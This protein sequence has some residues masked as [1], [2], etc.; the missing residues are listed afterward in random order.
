MSIFDAAYDEMSW[1][2]VC[3]RLPSELAVRAL[4]RRISDLDSMVEF[5]ENVGS[6]PAHII[7]VKKA[8][9]E[10]ITN[11]SVDDIFNKFEASKHPL[12]FNWL[13][14]GNAKRMKE[15][16]SKHLTIE[17]LFNLTDADDLEGMQEVLTR[18]LQENDVSIS[19]LVAVLSKVEVEHFQTLLDDV[20][21]DSR[22]E[23]RVSILGMHNRANWGE[24]SDLQK[25]IAIK[26]LA[27]CA[28]LTSD[29]N[30][31][32]HEN[33]GPN[34][35]QRLDFNLFTQLKPLERL[36][37]LKKYFSYFP[38]FHKIKVFDPPP[39]KEEWDFTLFAGCIEH[40]DIVN[41]LNEIYKKITED[42]PPPQD[43]EDEDDTP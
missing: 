15:F 11:N 43:D 37:A 42:D 16:G 4:Q 35:I 32:F 36:L 25:L 33:K 1:K 3:C 31:N 30:N 28:P 13:N 9:N 7:D 2:E 6:Q 18:C 8:V 23:V 12:L 24:V 38:E 27:K 34:S 17:F 22:P 10:V 14:D 19:K 40:N 29:P 5:M 21:A 20:L 41:D 39:T 26:A